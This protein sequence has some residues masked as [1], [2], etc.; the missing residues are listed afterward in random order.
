MSGAFELRF[1]CF[2]CFFVYV[3]SFMFSQFFYFWF[4]QYCLSK[5][6]P[7]CVN[8]YS[9]KEFGNK[10]STGVLC[11]VAKVGKCFLSRPSLHGKPHRCHSILTDPFAKLYWLCPFSVFYFGAGFFS[12]FFCFTF[13]WDRTP[14]FFFPLKSD[15][16]SGCISVICG[17]SATP[18][19][20][21]KSKQNYIFW[22]RTT[23]KKTIFFEIGQL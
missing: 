16:D 12:P 14:N 7:L 17:P 22:D 13:F 18:F 15:K 20:F 4:A 8:E 1:I 19:R 11:H 3:F 23:I 21:K 9:K 6:Q 10:N 2:S 5:T